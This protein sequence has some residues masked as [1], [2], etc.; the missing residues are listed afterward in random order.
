MRKGLWN[1]FKISIW[2]AWVGIFS[3]YSTHEQRLNYRLFAVLRLPLNWPPEA[4]RLH[5]TQG[6]IP[7]LHVL[8]VK[9]F[10]IIL[11]SLKGLSHEIYFKN[12]DKNSWPN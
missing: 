12:I 6:K 7:I 1:P 11:V 10:Q 9:G 2:Q 8:D 4:A 3:K 5:K